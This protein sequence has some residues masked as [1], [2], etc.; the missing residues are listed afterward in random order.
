MIFVYLNKIKGLSNSLNMRE[1]YLVSDFL[2]SISLPTNY[3]TDLE[4]FWSQKSKKVLTDFFC[5]I[6]KFHLKLQQIENF[7]DVNQNLN[8]PL[9]Q[10]INM[11]INNE[12]QKY[13]VNF[14]IFDNSF[15]CHCGF[16]CFLLM[17]DFLNLS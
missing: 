7:D 13:Q 6:S 11:N 10:Q 12:R 17:A 8:I 14:S 4:N 16:S 9:Q 5:E 1:S 2:Q 15:C 3:D